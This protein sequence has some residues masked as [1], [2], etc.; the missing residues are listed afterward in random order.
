MHQFVFIS[1]VVVFSIYYLSYTR[2]VPWYATVV[3]VPNP[4]RA[5]QLFT[6]L[7]ILLMTA[8]VASMTYHYV[9]S[10]M[11]ASVNST[12]YQFT[13]EQLM[14]LTAELEWWIKS[15]PNGSTYFLYSFIYLFIYGMIEP[16]L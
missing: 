1:L 12:A 2:F 5:I 14:A 11:I 10:I 9:S 6:N 7:M 8:S 15:N 16:F 13:N 3:R 4:N